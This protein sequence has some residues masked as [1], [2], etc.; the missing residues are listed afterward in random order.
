MFDKGEVLIWAANLTHR[1]DYIKERLLK[2]RNV[3]RSRRSRKVRYRKCRYNRRKPKGWL[4]PSLKS[5]LNNV[6]NWGRKLIGFAPISEIEV[7]TARFD[8]QLMANPEISG[9][10]YQQGEL[11]GYEVREYLLSKWGR[12]CAYC[13]KTGVPLQVEHIQAKQKH[14]S[15]RVGNLTIA[16]EDCNKKKGT[17]DIREFLAHDPKRLAKILA[18]RTKPL[19]HAAIMNAIRY[20]IGDALKELGLPVSFYTGGRTKFNRYQLGY[21]K[22]HWIDAACVG[23]TGQR[24]QIQTNFTPLYVKAMGRGNRQKCKM[25]HNGFPRLKWND[26]K[27][28]Y[29][30]EKPRGAKRVHGFQTG[31]IVKGTITRGKNKGTYIG[32]ITIIGTFLLITNHEQSLKI[33]SVYFY[34]ILIIIKIKISSKA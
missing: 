10:L 9:T 31:D 2:R 4:P 5:R 34:N 6:Y 3:R 16:C 15:N 28:K 32:R 33:L 23:Y 17:K 8:T 20:K 27:K 30:P 13:D 22:D 12:K 18:S 21:Q 29:E 14:G 25:Q 26:E 7:E 19:R 1:G 24:V 11:Q